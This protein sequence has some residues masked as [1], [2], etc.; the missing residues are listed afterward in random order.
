MSDRV[1][2][3]AGARASGTVQV[4][5][6]GLVGMIT[7]RGDLGEAGF[8]SGISEVTGLS[9]PEARQIVGEE[10]KL[11][12]MSP[13]ELLLICDHG[14]AEAKVA[15]LSTAMAGRHHM[16]VNVSDARAVFTLEGDGAAIREVLAKLTPADLRSGTFG[17]GEVRRTRLA[18]VPAAFWLDD[19]G[20]ATVVCFR[21]VAEYVFGLLRNASENGS[22][23]GYF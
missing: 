8:Q 22:G 1:S 17:P 3:L 6:A 20:R 23:V 9:V 21:S 12:W 10:V 14:E 11:A 4:S 2:A 16:A 13:D 15:A 5:E 7:I 18:Q 19:E